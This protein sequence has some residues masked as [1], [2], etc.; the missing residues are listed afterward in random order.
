MINTGGGGTSPR[1]R[2]VL[3]YGG[4]DQAQRLELIIAANR[5]RRSLLLLYGD[6]QEFHFVGPCAT[7]IS[8][9]VAEGGRGT[10]SDKPMLR[11]CR[12]NLL[13]CPAG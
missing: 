10:G 11:L 8:L 12:A 9:V 2:R 1:L 4:I 13:C 3:H 5:R 6:S 7:V